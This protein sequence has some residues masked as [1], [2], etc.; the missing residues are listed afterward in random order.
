MTEATIEPVRDGDLAE[1][2]RNFER[3]WGDHP[4]AEMLRHF[5]HPMFFREFADTAFVARRPPEGDRADAEI[6]GYLLGFVAPTGDGYI[7]FVA[8]RDDGRG[9]GLGRRLY[10]TFTAV[11]LER[12]ATALK[13]LTS[14]SNE[15]SIAFHRRMGFTEMTLDEDY[16][17]SG[18]ARIIMRRP[19]ADARRTLLHN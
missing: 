2:L 19:L 12:G 18:R 16:A 6:V 7:H 8:V 10:E 15:R 14:S 4:H 11:A 17:G 9:L 3:F 5:H 13:A 1:I